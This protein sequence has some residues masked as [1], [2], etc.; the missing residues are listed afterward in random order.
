M[1]RGALLVAVALAAACSDI[2]NHLLEGQQYEPGGAC[3]TAP[4]VIDD[5][6]GSDP[7]DNCAPECLLVPAEG[8]SAVFITTTCPPY[9]GY[10]APERQDAAHDAADPC[11]AAFTAYYSDAGVCTGL[12]GAAPEASMDAGRD[13]SDAAM[14][15]ATLDAGGEASVETSVEAAA[16]ASQGDAAPVD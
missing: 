11:L 8:G 12:D 2:N 10:P 6:P 5:L 16:D 13:A 15:D 3:L 9:P 1:R 14:S 4:T 7:G